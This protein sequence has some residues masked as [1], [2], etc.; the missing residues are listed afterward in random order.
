MCRPGSA[1]PGGGAQPVDRKAGGHQQNIPW[2]MSGYCEQ[3]EKE[4]MLGDGIC[5]LLPG[6]RAGDTHFPAVILPLA[7]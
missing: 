2:V 6:H 5:P 4:E 7:L 3:G 1:E